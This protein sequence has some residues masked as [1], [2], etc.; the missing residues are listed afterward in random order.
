MKFTS[1]TATIPLAMA[2]S[3]IA[4]HAFAQNA[5]TGTWGNRAAALGL[6]FLQWGSP[7][8]IALYL[9]AGVCAILAVITLINMRNGNRNGNG[10]VG[11][12]ACLI[13]AAVFAASAPSII[14]LSSQTIT[15]AAPSINGQGA[16][17]IQF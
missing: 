1:K 11:A 8:T 12:L 7:I 17:P 14:N 10:G 13:L 2:F 6:D 4:P 15:G 3:T 9:F 16:A 5:A